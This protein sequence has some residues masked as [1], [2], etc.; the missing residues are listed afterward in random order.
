MLI[1]MVMMVM[2]VRMTMGV[3]V[4]RVMCRSVIVLMAVVM[5]IVR[6]ALLM[7]MA[8]AFIGAAFGIEWRLDLDH[9]RAQSPDHG[10]DDVVPADAQA[11]R[12]DLRRQMPVAEMPGDAD[13]MLRI[14][15]S[16]LEQRLSSRHHFDEPLILQDQRIAATQC[17]GV[18]QVEQEFEPARRGHR[19]PPPVAI[20]EIEHDRVGGRIL[21][22]M[23]RFDFCR[24]DHAIN[25]WRN[26]KRRIRISRPCRR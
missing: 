2:A 14:A 16:D 13:Q 19:H 24:A 7:A 17:H 23:L 25:P 1:M 18:F 10:F 3:I 20:V 6:V 26:T 11:F 12:H 15:S 5:V 9:A 21:P 22:A 4:R 8:A